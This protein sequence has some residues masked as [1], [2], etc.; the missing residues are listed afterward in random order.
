MEGANEDEENL[1]LW[2]LQGE[3]L[4]G[5]NNVHYLEHLCVSFFLIIL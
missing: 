4:V 3:Q 1:L 2:L 5:E